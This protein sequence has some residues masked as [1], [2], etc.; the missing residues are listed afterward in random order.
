M[1]RA[2]VRIFVIGLIGGLAACAPPLYMRV[3]SARIELSPSN[4]LAQYVADPGYPSAEITVRSTDPTPRS[5]FVTV[6]N[7][8]L[9]SQIT[10]PSIS[11]RG[12]P[13]SPSS[14]QEYFAQENFRR[15][16]ELIESGDSLSPT[17]RSVVV[18]KDYSSAE[19][20]NT[21]TYRF[22][23]FQGNTV[24]QELTLGYKNP[25]PTRPTTLFIW[26]NGIVPNG[27]MNSVADYF[28]QVIFPTTTS[29]VGPHW[30]DHSNPSLVSSDSNQIHIILGKTEAIEYHPSSPSIVGFFYS[31]D[32]F[33]DE[34]DSFG[35]PV[36][37]MNAGMISYDWE[38]S[39]GVG[40][41]FWRVGI[42]TL[43]HELQHLV[44]FYQ[45]TVLRGSATPIWLD[46]LSSLMV[47][48][49]L[50]GPLNTTLGVLNPAKADPGFDLPAVDRYSQAIKALQVPI[51]QWATTANSIDELLAHYGVA[52]LFGAYLHR[53]SEG[54]GLLSTLTNSSGTG[55]SA[56]D[57]ALRAVGVDGGLPGALSRWVPAVLLSETSA[58]DLP[59][60][61]MTSKA[62][63]GSDPSFGAFVAP[64]ALLFSEGTG[65][66]S[67]FYWGFSLQPA[68]TLVHR[69]DPFFVGQRTWKIET[70][71]GSVLTFVLR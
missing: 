40:S 32:L 47:E 9:L 24:I 30:G 26:V 58:S 45:R 25:I 29:L 15:A 27:A 51:V 64:E 31:R 38:T 55:A 57:G 19:I 34:A 53:N 3:D 2:F 10:T 61:R 62:A 16:Q 68:S 48:D 50:T 60:Y 6:T 22:R 66:D 36:I 4:P 21:T 63:Q 35:A 13:L 59:G 8:D 12:T 69:M 14:P 20:G 44:N 70:P 42:S 71:P 52:A 11:S 65:T 46:E 1:F 28:S 23:D 18:N 49:A 17:S 39:G 54:A 56:L 5:L 43:G 7:T 41:W 33:L 67:G 37:V